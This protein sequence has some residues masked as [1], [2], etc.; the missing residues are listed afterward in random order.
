MLESKLSAK[1]SQNSRKFSMLSLKNKKLLRAIALSSLSVLVIFSCQLIFSHHESKR[2]GKEPRESSALIPLLSQSPQS[3]ASVLTEIANQPKLSYDRP[4]ASYLLAVDLLAQKKGAAALEYL[5]GLEQEYA[6]LAPQILLK[7]AQAYRQIQQESKCQK[8]LTYLIQTYP[9][10]PVVVDAWSLLNPDYSN[11]RDKLIQQFPYHPRTRAIALQQLQKNPQQFEWLSILAKYSR[12]QDLVAMR[13]RLVLQ[14]PAHLTPED[15]EA[16]ADGYWRDGENRKAADA[17]TLAT[18][19]PRNLYRAARG[20]HLNGNTAEAKRAYQR[21]LREYHDAREAGAALLDLA[22]ISGG[23]EA[24]VYLERAITLFPEFAPQAMGSKAIIHN[25]FGK[26]AAAEA[27]KQELLNKYSH[28]ATAAAYRWKIA[29]QQ[30]AE[31]NKQEAWHWMQPVVKS[32][33]NLDFAPE[34]LYWT[35][36]WATELGKVEEARSTWEKAIALYPQS[37]WAWR[38]AVLLGWDVGDFTT[39]R[40]QKPNLDFTETYYPLPIG[41]EALQE[42]YFL[43]QYRDAWTLLQGEIERSQQPTVKEQFTEGLL[44]LKLGYYSQGMQE[45]W[46]LA[47]RDDPQDI[48]QWEALRKTP[49]YWYGLFPFPYREDLLKYAAQQGINPLLVISVM[50]KE[51]TFAP[52]INSRVGAVGL[53]QI[54]P[55]TADWVAQQINLPNHVL[56]EPEDN[57]KIGTWYLA[58][59]HHRYDNDSLLAIASYNAGTSNVNQ[60][61]NQYNIKDS[62]RFVVQIPFPETQDY[63]EGVFGNYWNYL[64][65]YNPQVRQKVARYQSSSNIKH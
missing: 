43:R 32:E 26:T 29:Q 50:R 59:N 10:S 27:A 33:L 15:W 7:T 4:R 36:K 8:T 6:L 63:V 57:I 53:M 58:H 42:L 65:L 23:D 52:E 28:S 12:D 16:I 31:G 62:D 34:A 41:S 25:A 17:Y 2:L 46:Q 49:A 47:T 37:Y 1:T 45:I 5:V 51:S 3:R 22:S 60:W 61:L 56:T 14:Y 13:D 35:G 19:T 11:Y 64:R 55:A 21:L 54:V 24:I 38:A 18:S 48:Q 30:A 40:Q 44:L 9:D 20:F 39:V